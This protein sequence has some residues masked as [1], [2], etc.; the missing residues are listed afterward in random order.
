MARRKIEIILGA[1][2]AQCLVANY[3][4]AANPSKL[5]IWYVLTPAV[6]KAITWIALFVV[7]SRLMFGKSK[8]YSRSVYNLLVKMFGDPKKMDKAN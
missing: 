5:L 1:A 3:S 8:D 4:D 2:I 6:L 7:A